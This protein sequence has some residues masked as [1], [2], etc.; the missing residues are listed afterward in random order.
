MGIA[1]IAD[2]FMAL[3]NLAVL[4]LLSGTADASAGNFFRKC[5]QFED[6]GN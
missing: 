6:V 4:T 1:G 5:P 3:P 2:A